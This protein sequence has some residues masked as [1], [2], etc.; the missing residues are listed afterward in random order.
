MDA[1]RNELEGCVDFMEPQGGIHLW[2]KPNGE[3]DENALFKESIQNGVIFA[4]GTTLG[5][6]RNFMR[7]T[8]SRTEAGSIREGIRRFAEALRRFK[9]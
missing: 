5:S 1:L 3:W 8:Y 4:P 2:C 7:F 9:R 6:S